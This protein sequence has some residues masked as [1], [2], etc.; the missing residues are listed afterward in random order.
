MKEVEEDVKKE[1]NPVTGSSAGK[2][3]ISASTSTHTHTNAFSR[4]GGKR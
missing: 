3:H 1:E 2:Q 4:V